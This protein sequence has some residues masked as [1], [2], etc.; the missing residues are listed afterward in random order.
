MGKLF[1]FLFTLYIHS[2]DPTVRGVIQKKLRQTAPEGGKR[3]RRQLEKRK[4]SVALCATLTKPGKKKRVCF[5]I[6]YLIWFREEAPV[7]VR[8]F[9]L[10]PITIGN[11]K[12]LLY[13]LFCSKKTEFGGKAEF[14]TLN[15][16]GKVGWTLCDFVHM[17]M[18]HRGFCEKATEKAS[19]HSRV[20]NKRWMVPR[21]KE[22]KREWW[23]VMLL[24]FSLGGPK[25]LMLWKQVLLALFR[26]RQK[27][28]FYCPHI[29]SDT[30]ELSLPVYSWIFLRTRQKVATHQSRSDSPVI[31]S[32]S[33]AP[34][35]LPSLFPSSVFA[36][37]C[38]LHHNRFKIS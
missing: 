33:R 8:P 37:E 28:P 18:M 17:T 23:D 3:D 12:E 26:Y 19:H 31:S 1:A 24:L 14:Q 38:F 21:P 20:R 35:F 34:P 10:G 4:G 9:L 15:K 27:E 32:S 11:G 5:F 22:E 36:H 6:S 29:P 25:R 30:L 7:K 13:V 16:K 2:Y